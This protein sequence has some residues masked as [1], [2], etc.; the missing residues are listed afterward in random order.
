[1]SSSNLF[2]LL[3]RAA[4]TDPDAPFF[5]FHDTTT[6]Y[7][8]ALDAT[9]RLAAL[10]EKRGISK[11]D[12]VLIHLQNN[13]EFIYALFAV[14]QL[15]AIGVLVNPST[16]RYELRHYCEASDP[17]AVISAPP[18]REHFTIDGSSIYDT[19][20]IITIQKNGNMPGEEAPLRHEAAT[21]ASDPAVMIFTS[22]MEGEALGALLTHH[23]IIESLRGGLAD[24][25]SEDDRFISVL[26][27][28]HSF[29]L[30][31]SLLLPLCAR[32]PIRLMERFSPR[33]ILDLL[34]KGA[35][36]VF[37]GVPAM[38][39]IIHKIL[40]PGSR[41]PAMRLWISGGEALSIEL[42]ERL[43]DEHGI[44][45]RQ[46]YGLTEAS[47]IVSCNP[48]DRPNRPGSIGRAMPYNTVG[49]LQENASGPGEIL[50]KGI[51]VIP[52]YYRR[53]DKTD[54]FI[55]DGWL[56]TGDIG[57]ADTDGYLYIPGR[58]KDML[59]KKGFNVYPREVDRIL[60]HHP[61]V[62]DVL[63]SGHFSR[64]P[65]ST[66]TEVLEAEIYRKSGSSLDEGSLLAWCH[67]NMTPYKIPDRIKITE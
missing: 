9:R 47:P 42:Q 44:E 56:H 20:R 54:Q 10:L 8:E 7:A 57:Y 53:P 27:L 3:L 16:G 48:P 23:G 50:V 40:P 66:F 43:F 33:A 29:G 11:G 55:R 1:V 63:I 12:R 28:F 2:S 19:S 61:L 14:F 13:P 49:F 51:N 45:L 52:G 64:N 65:D 4:D 32:S 60:R 17:S 6:S 58:K 35:M 34:R 38:F 24:F 18:Q 62:K 30:I 37:C 22:A 41:F 36:S 59:I 25:V 15:G 26:P 46:G 21:G 5:T 39:A 31:S 67:E